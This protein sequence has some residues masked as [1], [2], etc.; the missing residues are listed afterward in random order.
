MILVLLFPLICLYI[1]PVLSLSITVPTQPHPIVN[2]STL[3]LLTWGSDDPSQFWIVVHKV[4]SPDSSITPLIQ[5][6]ENFTATRNVSLVF[7]YAGNTSI[8]AQTTSLPLARTNVTFAYSELFQ[9]DEGP[10]HNISPSSTRDADFPPVASAIASS[11]LGSST[12]ASPSATA[13]SSNP[14]KAAIIGG[15]VCGAFLL[16]LITAILL[17]WGRRKHRILPPEGAFPANL[18][19]DRQ[20]IIWPYLKRSSISYLRGFFHDER[21]DMDH[22]PDVPP[23][24]YS[25]LI[26]SE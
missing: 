1:L 18:E 25:P 12:I 8:E 14:H 10:T 20:H 16:A 15:V 9:V 13:S 19:N 22:Y 11:T 5:K 26:S 2:A 21:E 17:A 7:P 24:P 4:S 23:P 6:V 3:V